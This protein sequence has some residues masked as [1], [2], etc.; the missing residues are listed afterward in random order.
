VTEPTNRPVLIIAEVGSVHDGSFGNAKKLIEIAGELGAGVVKF[1]THI[2]SAETLRNAPAPRYFSGEP[3]FEYF[4]RTAFSKDQW[5]QLKNHCT[6]HRTEFLSSP[7]SV[8]AVELLEDIGV[9][10]YKIGSG[11]VSNI[12]L[13][14]AVAQ[15]G[16]P[17]LLSSGMSTWA[18]LDEAVQTVLRKH[19]RLTLLQCTSEYPCLY[20]QVGLNVMLEMRERY[21]LPVGLSDH[22]LTSNASVA[23][24]ALGASVIEKHLT[25]SRRM[26]GSDARH[27][28]EPDEFADLVQAIRAVE[29]ILRSPVDKDAKAAELTEMKT[30]FE[31]SVVS[32]VDIP[33]GAL[34]SAGMLTVKKPGT[35]IP[36]RRLKELV[37]RRVV[38][39]V[40][41]DTQLREDDLDA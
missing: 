32:T 25:F 11:E 13:L 24:V 1:Q 23:A 34:L 26:Y 6:Q 28:L 9:G 17:I 16:K 33:A 3:R 19:E 20:D 10:S 5:L 12:P 15:T 41:K 40:R 14:E 39:D 18:E 8:E 7:F 2:A 21:K 22:T 35:G 37:G 31:K 36:A 29:T 27:S 30:I 38:R 4:E